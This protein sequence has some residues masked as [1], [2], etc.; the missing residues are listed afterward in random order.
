MCRFVNIQEIALSNSSFYFKRIK[1][2][3]YLR[4]PITSIEYEEFNTQN[5]NL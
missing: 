1:V 5:L 4:T 2:K 3:S